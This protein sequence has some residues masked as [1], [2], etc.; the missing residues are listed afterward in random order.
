MQKNV[1]VDSNIVSDLQR[2]SVEVESRKDLIAFMIQNGMDLESDKFKQYEDEYKKFFLEY[3][4]AKTKFESE[5]CK[6][7]AAKEGKQLQKWDLDFGSEEVTL[8]F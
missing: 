3:S 4:L 1:K 7:E 2:L 6:P 8:T 5:F